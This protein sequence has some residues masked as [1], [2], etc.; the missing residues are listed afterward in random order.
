MQIELKTGEMPSLEAAAS[1]Q[2]GILGQKSVGKPKGNAVW[3]K[4]VQITRF[5]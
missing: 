1:E 3:A 5:D 4:V 2:G